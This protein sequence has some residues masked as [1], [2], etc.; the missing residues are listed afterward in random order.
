MSASIRICNQAMTTRSAGT[1]TS[2]KTPLTEPLSDARPL[3]ESM[4]C[5]P[6]SRGP[7]DG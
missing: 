3:A 7:A 1:L 2:P 4:T 6:S 5:W